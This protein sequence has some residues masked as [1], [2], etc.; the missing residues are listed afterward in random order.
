MK[1]ISEDVRNDER[2]FLEEVDSLKGREL[3]SFLQNNSEFEHKSGRR[4]NL[5]AKGYT[6]RL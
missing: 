1:M 4:D 2:K 6:N 5:I 3:P